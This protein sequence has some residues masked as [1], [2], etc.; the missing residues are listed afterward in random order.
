[1]LKTQIAKQRK[2]LAVRGVLV[3]A[4]A[5]ALVGAPGA[6]PVVSSTG[7]VA[8]FA[9]AQTASRVPAPSLE[10]AVEW[11]NTDGPVRL[12]DL[13][14]KVVLMDFWTYC[15][16]NCI[17][18]I[19]ALRQLEEKYPNEL[20]VIGVHSAKFETEKDSENIQKAVLRYDLRHPIV[21]D[22]N[23]VL[24]HRYSVTSWPSFRLIDPEGFVVAAGSGEVS[25]KV[26]DEAVGAL[27]RRHRRKGTLDESPRRF[28]IAGDAGTGAPLWFPGKVLADG[29]SGR[30]FIADSG[31]N[32]IVI[33]TLE[34]ERLDVVGSGRR[35]A[36][37]GPFD[38]A[39]FDGPQGM[40]LSADTLYVADTGNHAIRAIDLRSKTV[41]TLAGTGRQAPLGSRGGR[42]DRADL[43]SP[44]DLALVDDKLFIAMA[45]LHQIWRLDLRRENLR[46][47]SGSGSE[48]ILDGSLASAAHAQPSGIVADGE[49][50]FVVDSEGNAVRAVSS[51]SRGTVRTLVGP[52]GLP[53][54]QSLFA[55]GDRDGQGQQV[56]LQHPVGLAAHEG[57]LF[58]ADTYNHKIK[59]IDPLRRTCVTVLGD[60]QRGLQDDP[61]RFHEPSGLSVGNGKLFIADT[62]NHRVRVAELATGKVRTLEISG[63][64]PPVEAPTAE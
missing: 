53:Q 8:H 19:P 44:W 50:L 30:L 26:L 13:R 38:Q 1:M 55:F 34:G 20:V 56:R 3:L 31:H 18:M 33:A 7:S 49:T 4:L 28:T 10:G 16:I 39:S 41:K 42:L 48:D 36:D 6:L 12:E 51:D 45:G 11:I 58:V 52:V 35:G 61:P 15:C 17:H 9:A 40:A 46:P 57:T 32:R 47:H 63:L 43:A 54:A 60:G 59:Q 2:T 62:N 29:A 37:D 25:F 24:W 22:A 5:A 23:L 64:E 14:G 27:V 21:N